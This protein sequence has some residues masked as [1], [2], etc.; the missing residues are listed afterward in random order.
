MIT[1]NWD[2]E[3]GNNSR[4]T[5]DYCFDVWNSTSIGICTW[6]AVKLSQFWTHGSIHTKNNFKPLKILI[7]DNVYVG[8][9]SNFAPG[10]YVANNILIGL[11]SFV[12]S[13]F[14]ETFTII[15]VIPAVVLKMQTDWRQNW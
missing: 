5:Y 11:R 14:N 8:S 1:G 6:I 3:I 10:L 12:N 4:V 13:I 2:F 9:N 15:L 7:G